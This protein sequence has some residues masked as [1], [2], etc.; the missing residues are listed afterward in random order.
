M[1]DE[2]QTYLVA[3]CRPW[4]RGA[5]DELSASGNG[6]WEL[7]TEKEALSRE[8]LEELKPGKVFFLHWSWRIPATVFEHFECIGFHMTDLPYGRGGSPLQNLILRGHETT[9]LSAFGIGDQMDGGPVYLKR[10][11]ALEGSAHEIFE[12]AMSVAV[13]MIQAIVKHDPSPMPQVGE[14]V[15][16]KRRSPK[17]SEIPPGLRG[18]ALYDFIRM[19]DADGYPRAFIRRGDQRREY[20]NARLSESGEV[21]ADVRV[22][23]KTGTFSEQYSKL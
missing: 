21:S 18:R 15:T 1:A 8:F 19:L 23:G 10:D 13:G 12:R 9:K 4:C 17:E 16:F 3:G 2:P 5:F 14:P 7:V 11:L 6:R 22:I 20:Y